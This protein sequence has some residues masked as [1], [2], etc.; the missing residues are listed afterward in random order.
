[1]R[2]AAASTVGARIRWLEIAV[3][4]H[5]EAVEAV[6]EILSR[7][8]H[9]G[10][11]VE[12]PIA[13]HGGA[14]HTVKA[15]LVEDVDAVAKVADAR[16]ALGHLQA[17][18]LGPIGE[19]AVRVVDDEDWLE[20][21]KATLTPIRI[22][23]FLVRPTWSDARQDGAITIALDPGMAFG[24]G[25]HPTTQQCLEA[26]SYLDLEGLRVLDVGT[27]SGILGIA[28]AKRGAREVIGV[29]TDPLA[30]RAAR[31]NADA[32]GVAI[33][34]R[35]GSAADVDG[36]FDVVLANLVGPV[37]VQVA[38]HLRARLQT[39]GSLVAAGITTQAERDVL[40]AFVAEGL[41]VVDR[42]ERADWVRLVMTA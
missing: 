22:G 38:P 16:D 33:D 23:R 25:L 37:L 42:D 4:A 7:Y 35:I 31:E 18:G 5:A 10:I 13:P 32:N 20:A 41:G 1:M 24:T 29:D 34:A 14:D 9:N 28:A 3:P 15:Y 27:G 11:A 40:S 19:V 30:V 12:L 2:W 26:V 8:G 39:S 21:W 17:F 6:S 36:T